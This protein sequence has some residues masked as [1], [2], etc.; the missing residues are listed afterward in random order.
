MPDAPE[1]RQPD[2]ITARVRRRIQIARPADAVAAS[3]KVDIKTSVLLTP[4]QVDAAVKV[5]GDY[6]PPGG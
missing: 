4:E 2:L 5:T 6:R 1:A 3:G